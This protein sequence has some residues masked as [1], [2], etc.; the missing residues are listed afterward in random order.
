MIERLSQIGMMFAFWLGTLPGCSLLLSSLRWSAAEF[1][2]EFTAAGTFALVAGLAGLAGVKTRRVPL[3]VAL[4][5]PI[6]V[7]S[8]AC[9]NLITSGMVRMA[10]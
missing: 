9:S 2:R 10:K 6:A 8:F 5:A 7:C 3:Q 1:P 4:F